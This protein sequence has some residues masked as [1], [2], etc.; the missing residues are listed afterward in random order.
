M[1]EKPKRQ[2][3]SHIAVKLAFGIILLNIRIC[4]EFRASDFEFGSGLTGL[5][6]FDI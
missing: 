5:G 1:T 3:P 2:K 4:F 6:E